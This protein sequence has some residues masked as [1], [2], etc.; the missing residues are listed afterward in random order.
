M[1]AS[2]RT[3]RSPLPGPWRIVENAETLKK[4]DVPEK[5]KG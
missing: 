4:K 5:K 3:T 2:T 1:S